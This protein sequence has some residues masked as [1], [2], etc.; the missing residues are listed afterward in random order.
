MPSDAMTASDTTASR[1]HMLLYIPIDITA[2]WNVRKCVVLAS[3]SS[4][5]D[6]ENTPVASSF[7]SHVSCL[8]LPSSPAIFHTVFPLCRPLP[9]SWVSGHGLWLPAPA[10]LH[11]PSG[12]CSSQ[13]SY[14]E[15]SHPPEFLRELALSLQLLPLLRLLLKWVLLPSK[16]NGSSR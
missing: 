12:C 16:L 7:H 1:G 10:L 15:R 4:E 13:P 9:Q 2:L 14:G 8:Q 5:L 6:L 11:Q 3:A